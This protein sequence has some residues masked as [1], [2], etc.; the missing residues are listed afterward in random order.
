MMIIGLISTVARQILYL[1]IH[2]RGG[3]VVDMRRA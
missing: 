1:E 2:D 3:L